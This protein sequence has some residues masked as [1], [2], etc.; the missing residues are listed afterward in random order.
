MDGK[1]FLAHIVTF[2]R[3]HIITSSGEIDMPFES[4]CYRLVVAFDDWAYDLQERGKRYHII[5]MEDYV[6]PEFELNSLTTNVKYVYD[7]YPFENMWDSVKDVFGI[8][9]DKD[10]YLNPRIEEARLLHQELSKPKTEAGPTVI[11]FCAIYQKT[12]KES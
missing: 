5:D 3:F 4:E 12:K 2:E 10:T 6:I 11:D 9:E 1:V 8:P 7:M